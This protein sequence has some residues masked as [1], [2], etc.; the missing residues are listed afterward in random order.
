MSQTNPSRVERMAP[1]PFTFRRLGSR[2]R[3]ACDHS[4][5]VHLGQCVEQQVA[6]FGIGTPAR[7]QSSRS[8]VASC[9][10]LD[11]TADEAFHRLPEHARQRRRFSAG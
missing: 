2:H 11:I 4:F 6:P 1:A 9:P 8:R 7:R 5:A 3:L 10:V